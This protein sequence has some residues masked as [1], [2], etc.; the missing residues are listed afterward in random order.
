MESN[1]RAQ[2]QVIIKTVF[3]KRKP[4]ESEIVALINRSEKPLKL[5]AI[6]DKLKIARNYRSKAKRIL[7]E[8]IKAGLIDKYKNTYVSKNLSCDNVV[9]GKVEL[10]KDFGF[11]LVD[12]GEDIFLNK[13]TIENLLPGDEIEIYI[14]KSKRGRKEGDLKKIIKRTMTPIVCKII[15]HGIYFAVPLNR[16]SPFINING[17][18]Q[19]KEGDIILLKIIGDNNKLNG[20]IISK[21]YD[22]DDIS[23][24]KE[25]VLNKYEICTTFTE[26]V[27]KEAENINIDYKDILKRVD[28]RNENI[29]TID[30]VDAKDFDDAVS[31]T[32]Q[33]GFYFLGVHIADV[34]KY[35]KEGTFLDNEARKR[36]FSTYL[37][38]EVFPML[39]EKLSSDI[40][41]LRENEDRLTFSIFIKMDDNAEIN[42]YDIKETII[43]NKKR[44]T[45][46]EVQDI[47]DNKKDIKDKQIRDMLLLMNELKEKL[48]KK[49]W[50][51]GN[52]DFSLG[53]PVLLYDKNK[54]VIDIKRKE[55][56]EA[57]KII[58]YFMI[59]ANI[60]AADFI[61]KKYKYGIFRIH[62]EPFKNDILEFNR[63]LKCLGI[64]EKLK[65]A[66]NKEFQKILNVAAG[67]KE[68]YL[69]EKNLLKAMPVAKY[70][71]KN[72]GHFGLGLDK[73]T[74]F[75]SPIRRY[76]DLLVHRMIK[77]SPGLH[78]SG[79][80]QRNQLKVLSSYIS[81]R[82]EKSE[83]A[84]NEI[85]NIYAMDFL[86]KKIGETFSATIIKIVKSGIIV[87]LDKY[88]VEG[89][90]NFD[91]INDDYYFYD[92]ERMQATGKK[93]KKNY[94]L[95][96]KI[97]VIIVKINMDLQK[98][99]LEIDE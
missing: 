46:E 77:N 34:S 92:G 53:E 27:I 31:L 1:G 19:V 88:P 32:R 56:L 68:Q 61:L 86:R 65:K 94:K 37:P 33:N 35:V 47:L 96:D 9:S 36:A 89:F 11:L 6:L 25:F 4:I 50:Q 99:L 40:C 74:H 16:E 54:K 70:S 85:F 39:P 55:T 79:I 87:E 90:I 63:F 49:F 51:N 17:N 13:K 80:L 29:I 98:L 76:A 91:T 97:S 84:E 52:I 7:R 14:K 71:E 43:K 48:K 21:L 62:P 44:F 3:M 42:T 69:I 41:S 78:T 23:Q 58:E 5:N 8:L 10:K 73:Y 28:L 59:L 24:Y 57:H 83:N 45:Y 22:T 2:K 66:T 93:T 15:K 67:H 72:S 75:T 64:R 18:Y 26:D 60:C 95:G 82:E 20:N 81:E 12:E 30:P 38:G